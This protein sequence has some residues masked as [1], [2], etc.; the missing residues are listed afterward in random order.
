MQTS[1]KRK[2]EKRKNKRISCRQ[3]EGACSRGA[4]LEQTFERE[5]ESLVRFLLNSV[6]Q[7]IDVW[8]VSAW[9]GPKQFLII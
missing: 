9:L 2:K 3:S 5:F 1:G 6:N 8:A 4:I 7:K